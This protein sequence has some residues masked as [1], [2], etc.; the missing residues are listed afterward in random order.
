[1][2]LPHA[3]LFPQAIMPLHIFEPRYQ[4]LVRDVLAS[5]RIFAV[6]A[7]DEDTAQSTGQFEPPFPTATLGLIR[8]CH[9]NPDGT[10]NLALQ[11]LTRVSL[12]SILDEQP[13]RKSAVTPL[14][15]VPGGKTDELD[16]LRN[17]LD[18]LI[19][20]RIQD[21]PDVPDSF[22]QFLRSID[23]PDVY[24]DLTAYSLCGD[25]PIKQS[26]LEILNTAQRLRTLKDWL[27]QCNAEDSLMRE[28]EDGLDEDDIALN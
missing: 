18:D 4:A 5:N 28:L 1:M 26:L 12:N 19:H 2:T 8:I 6:A 13:Y 20:D 11:G 14:V 16:R 17:D 3:V 25:T 24:I 7:L 27:L 22:L 21:D 23:D 10:Y 9:H 15:S